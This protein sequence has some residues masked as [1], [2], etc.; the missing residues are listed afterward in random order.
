MC[1]CKNLTILQLFLMRLALQIMKKFLLIIFTIA[2]LQVLFSQAYQRDWS[3]YFGDNSLSIVGCTEFRGDVYIAGKITD[4]PNTQSLISQLSHQSD[5]GG[6]Q[7]DGF[8]AKIS[9][10]GQLIWFTYYGGDGDDVINHVVAD[11]SS[12]YVVGSTSSQ[13]MATTGVHQTSMN[14]VTDGFIAAF[15]ED[16]SLQW[17]TYFGGE[18]IDSIASLT[19]YNNSIYLYGSTKSHTSIATTGAFQQ[20]IEADGNTGD[21]VNSFVAEF[22]K[23]GQRIWATYYGIAT[24]FSLPSDYG[25][26][27]VT[28]IAINE[29]GLYVSGWDA[30]VHANV[31]YFGTPGA[32]LEI[33]PAVNAMSLYLSKFSFDGNRLWSTYFNAYSSQGTPT[34]ISPLFRSTDDVTLARSLTA[35]SNGVYM[36]GHT[37]GSQ[38]VGTTGA[39][40][41][42]KGVL[43]TGFIVHFSD[44]GARVW[45]SYLSNETPSLSGSLSSDAFENIYIAGSTDLSM[46]GMPTTDAYQVQKNGSSD[47]Y[48]AKISADG[49]TKIYGTYYGGNDKET[50]GWGI[51]ISSGDSFYL[52]GTTLST[53]GMTTSGAWQEDLIYIDE[54]GLA[55]KNILIAK[56]TVDDLSI[57]DSVEN[58]FALYPNP[59]HNTIYIESNFNSDFEINIFDVV[60]KKILHKTGNQNIESLDVS[61]LSKGVYF[62]RIRDIRSNLTQ[63]KKIIKE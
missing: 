18:G 21:Y 15:S 47:F 33:K 50:D 32:F 23:S 36:V 55:K 61:H 49:T 8:L 53:S 59:A 7:W 57:Q 46:P 29:T 11:E 17:H 51:P 45:G 28:G 34:S 27:P 25:Q 9:P 37:V 6:G 31:T 1:I 48:F 16:G 54:E 42:T 19:E 41:P 56:F 20:T 22:S 3:T 26:T 63:T 24:I 5:Y 13:A 4:S 60:G 44:V 38:G 12:V 43:S 10:E 62:V 58:H 52:V 30:G 39:F 2:G 40:Q 35:T 14:G